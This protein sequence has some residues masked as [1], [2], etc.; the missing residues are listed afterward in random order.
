M[1][2]G[3][4]LRMLASDPLLQGVDVVIVVRGRGA[5]GVGSV[6]GVRLMGGVRL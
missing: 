1:T 3:I 2:E 5:W 4:L 6:C